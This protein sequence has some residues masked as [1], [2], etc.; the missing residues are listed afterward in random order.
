MY[1]NP[2]FP[3]ATLT[4]DIYWD[5]KPKP[6]RALRDLF[7]TD[8]GLA[9][10]QLADQG[11][12]IDVPIMVYQYDPV[13]EMGMRQQAGYTW[14]PSAKQL[15]IPVAPGL[16]FPGAPTYDPNNPPAG[17]IKVSIDADD[18]PSYDPPAPPVILDTHVVGIRV[19]GNVYGLGPGVW[20]DDPKRPGAKA[21]SVNG[22]FDN[23]INGQVVTQDGVSYTAHWSDGLMGVSLNFTRGVNL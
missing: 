20:V 3:E 22:K 5:N 1:S 12:T 8:V 19:F 7:P 15:P 23:N 2:F 9:A 18:Y 14:V 10:V 11:Y 21:Q 6:V 17:S 4:P 16:T 13:T